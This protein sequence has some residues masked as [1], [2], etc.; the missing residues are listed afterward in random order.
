M[1]ITN[2][3]VLVHSCFSQRLGDPKPKKC[4]CKMFITYAAAK[5]RVAEGIADWLILYSKSEKVYD[6]IDAIVEERGLKTPRSNTLE[7]AHMERNTEGHEEQVASVELYQELTHDSQYLL[8]YGVILKAGRYLSGEPVL[9]DPATD[10]FRGRAI[11][12]FFGLDQRTNYGA[13]R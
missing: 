11:L 7:K 9:F 10:A 1:S 6:A 3:S 2:Y 13:T 5:E 8:M 4:R 12:I